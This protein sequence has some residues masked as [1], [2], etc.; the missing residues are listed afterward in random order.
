MELRYAVGKPGEIS[1]FEFHLRA[2]D[3]GTD[4]TFIHTELSTGASASGQKRSLDGTLRKLN[5]AMF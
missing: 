5:T 2:T 3:T 4:L 1:R